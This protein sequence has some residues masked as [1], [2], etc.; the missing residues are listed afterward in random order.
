MA[1]PPEKII[2]ALE[3]DGI[4]HYEVKWSNGQVTNELWAAVDHF[5]I[6]WHYHHEHPTSLG[7]HEWSIIPEK[8]TEY[9][10]KFRYEP[11]EP[12]RKPEWDW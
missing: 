8:V 9:D 11:M 3:Y 4:L 6:T 1:N 2:K 7:P 5:E 12:L 10:L